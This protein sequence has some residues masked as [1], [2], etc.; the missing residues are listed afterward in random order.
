LPGFAFYHLKH[1]PRAVGRGD[2]AG[3]ILLIGQHDAAARDTEEIR[4][5]LG[6]MAQGF[7][8]TGAWFAERREPAQ[9]SSQGVRINRHG[10]PDSGVWP[11]FPRLQ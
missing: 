8:N 9:T 3:N 5:C 6:H 11:A 1:S 7:Y 2:I 10:L 4:A